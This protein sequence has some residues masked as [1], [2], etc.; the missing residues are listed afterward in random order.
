M[1]K[2]PLTH[3]SERVDKV[4]LD[5]FLTYANDS[6]DLGRKIYVLDAQSR[7]VRGFRIELADQSTYPGRITVHGGE[8]YDH[9][10]KTLFNEDQADVSR[11]ITLEGINADFYVEVEFI[12]S[13]SDSDARAFWDPTVDQGL[14]VSGDALLD[15]QELSTTVATRK[16]PDWR[17]VQPV[18]T[19]NFQRELVGTLNSTRVPLVRISTD[20]SNEITVAANPQLSTEKAATIML[21]QLS[22][23]QIRVQ[24]TQLFRAGQTITV[25]QHSGSA[26]ASTISAVDHAQS[27][28]T[29]STI[30]FTGNHQPGAIVR[31]TDVA[32]PDFIDEAAYGRYRRDPL[33]A[34][35]ANSTI[36]YR[37]KLY[38]GDE[39]HGKILSQGFTGLFDKNDLNLQSLKDYVDFLSSQLFEMKWGH[40]DPYT[41]STDSSRAPVGLGPYTSF[42]PT[43]RYYDRSDG[44]MASRGPMITV[45]DG[46]DSY[47]DFN[48]TDH[49]P[50]NAALGVLPT[51]GG[52]IFI[53]KGTYTITSNV[54]ITSSGKVII[55]GEPG[56]NITCNGGNVLVNMAG[57]LVIQDIE[58][59]GT[60][61]STTVLQ[62]DTT[63]PAGLILDRVTFTDGRFGVD[64]VLPDLCVFRDCV[65]SATSAW[66]QTVSL[67]FCLSTAGE[68]NGL[69]QNCNFNNVASTASN[70]VGCFSLT[71]AAT[72]TTTS[73]LK[74]N[75]CQFFATNV[76]A[77][78]GTL[79]H[80]SDGAQ[81]TVI[82]YSEFN[83]TGAAYHIRG[84]GG[85]NLKVFNCRQID[86]VASLI[87]LDDMTNIWL[88]H[89][90]DGNAGAD[91][92]I[93]NDCSQVKILNNTLTAN[94]SSSL[95]DAAI[96]IQST[97]DIQDIVI[98]DNHITGDTTNT[99][100]VGVIFDIAGTFTTQLLSINN[101]TFDHLEVCL[102]FNN[103]SG[104][105][106]YDD[107]LIVDNF[108]QDSDST[109]VQKISIAG[110]DV[111][112]RN[113]NISNNIFTD[114]RAT[115]GT[116]FSGRGRIGILMQGTANLQF[117]ISNNSFTSL[118]TSSLECYGIDF[119]DKTD[120]S[121]I[122]DNNIAN[123]L[124]TTI[125]GI[126]LSD[127]NY[128]AANISVTGNQILGIGAST[129]ASGI[130]FDGIIDSKIKGNTISNVSIS[131][132]SSSGLIFSSG[133]TATISR[134]NI[135]DNVLEF[136]GGGGSV[137]GIALIDKVISD[138]NILGNIIEGVIH[139]VR[140]ES[141]SNSWNRINISNNYILAELAAA[142]GISL[143]NS[144]SSGGSR[145]V[146]VQGN[147]VKVT[148]VSSGPNA[149]I[150]V[151]YTTQASIA[152][153]FIEFYNGGADLYG[154]EVI[155]S[156]MYSIHGNLFY[157]GSTV[158]TAHIK[159]DDVSAV[160]FA[161]LHNVLEEQNTANTGKTIDTNNAANPH[162]V[163]LNF[164]RTAATDDIDTGAHGVDTT[165]GGSPTYN[166]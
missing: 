85:D 51:A 46:S 81:N 50:I 69:F 12:E 123:F 166:F 160:A 116:L 68:I 98:A 92:I 11:T 134:L 72:S 129:Y 135:S 128:S 106:Y 97:G 9:E 75:N 148:S 34:V 127:S 132:A 19:T 44:L 58:L 10:G 26:E 130:E 84:L 15:G 8:A 143:W 122:S 145:G 4:D 29:I 150:R 61:T 87:G 79:V 32:A 31:V 52:T 146:V 56:T 126:R 94:S 2:Y 115:S 37:D 119:P 138:V 140:I 93:C 104:F 27:L 1:P 30:N 96:K 158:T 108:F 77:T 39:V 62:V 16:T 22:A 66:M 95:T 83:C 36:D 63:A 82:E 121:I 102:Y 111:Q 35:A 53:K 86:S 67:V 70:T 118:G 89:N 152:N 159:S 107:V 101:N 48:G 55:I 91:A 57:S 113:W 80:L 33:E 47:G 74:F 45:G 25:S 131:S 73:N 161:I 13:D 14:D 43:P 54:N 99:N 164:K 49:T 141:A 41:S 142:H 147:T 17:I 23:T 137:D 64:V 144:T 133:A 103:S 117:V 110:V 3:A 155:N 157:R 6:V 109:V 88:E 40:P 7:I 60:A 42:P 105:G 139:G 112:K 151:N 28:L 100:T 156:T 18:S 114:I 78:T 90:K 149:A 38:R 165:I 136:T 124:G 71:G 76:N 21:K 24:N 154:V 125:V 162:I 153:N 20:G 120:Y 59:T 163:G 65:F 5:A